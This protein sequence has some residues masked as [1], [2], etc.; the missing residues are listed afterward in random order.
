[1]GGEVSLTSGPAHI[2][3]YQYLTNSKYIGT[4]SCH[5]DV[6]HIHSLPCL[7][8]HSRENVYVWVM[9]VHTYMKMDG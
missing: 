7:D 4:L 2:Y 8:Q 9:F 6:H 3:M 5:V 1:M